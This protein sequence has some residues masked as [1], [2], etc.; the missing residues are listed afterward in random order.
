M[1]RGNSK[2]RTIIM[3]VAKATE[4]KKP[5]KVTVLIPPAPDGED[6]FV[7]VGVNGVIIKIKRGVAV[8]VDPCYKEVLDN[9]SIAHKVLEQHQEAAS[10]RANK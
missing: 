10:K 4:A 7:L 3:A 8:Q 9:A 2:E 5:E 1:P 6:N